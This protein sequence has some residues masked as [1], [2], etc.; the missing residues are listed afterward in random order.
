MIR[1]GARAL[2]LLVVAA[3]QAATAQDTG[4]RGVVRA[5]VEAWIATELNT[6]VA[7]IPF[8]EGETFK[9]G[10]TLLALDCRKF[11][12]E[13]RSATA[14]EDIA[15]VAYS[16]AVELDKRA[17]VGKFEVRQAAAQQEKARAAKQMAQLKVSYC[18]IKAPFDGVLTD[19]KIKAYE[20][21]TPNQPMIRIVNV[22][23]LELEVILASD[24]L[25]WLKPGQAF[26]VRIDET[27]LDYQAEIV[28]VVPVV[29]AASQTIRVVG[30]FRQPP[31][32]VLPGMSFSVRFARP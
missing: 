32:N 20:T 6:Q 11:E 27:G 5:P 26:D 12:A 13:L 8:R 4:P 15:G 3:M 23:D 28:R 16:N 7:A 21:V 1:R 2:L 22:S 30:K 9:T 25:K 10:D 29:D 31:G 24:T 19:Q 18:T 17:A 14:E